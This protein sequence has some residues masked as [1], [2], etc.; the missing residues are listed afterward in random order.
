MSKSKKE[1]IEKV[2][3]V[4][5]LIL[6]GCLLFLFGLV[7]T[8]FA[9][10]AGNQN[11]AREKNTIYQSWKVRRYY[12]NGKLVIQDEK[13]SAAE[14]Q[15]KKDSN[16]AWLFPNHSMPLKVWISSDGKYLFSQLGEQIPQQETIYELTED[17]LRFG[18][19]TVSAHYEFVMEPA[20]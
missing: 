10:D 6:V 9:L 17:R 11:G 5:I 2:I 8:L 3:K 19:R 16:A 4:R 18:K 7:A 20:R 1:L 12:K 13:F 14:F 15:I